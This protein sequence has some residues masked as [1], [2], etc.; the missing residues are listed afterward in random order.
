MTFTV[1]DDTPDIV[2]PSAQLE[3][4]DNRTDVNSASSTSNVC[5][6]L[7][8]LIVE[9]TTDCEDGFDETIIADYS[10]D[11]KQGMNTNICYSI[12]YQYE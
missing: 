1:P 5:M 10:E 3:E 7:F 11:P 8:D 2:Q 12:L 4:I 6:N 9:Q